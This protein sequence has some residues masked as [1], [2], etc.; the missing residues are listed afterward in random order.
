LQGTII[1]LKTIDLGYKIMLKV[2]VGKLILGLEGGVWFVLE[3]YVCVM[4]QGGLQ[5]HPG[6]SDFQ[7][8]G[9]G[10]GLLSQRS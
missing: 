3:A 5:I 10:Q 9:A 2:G 1:A 8:G 6:T 7:C 4:L